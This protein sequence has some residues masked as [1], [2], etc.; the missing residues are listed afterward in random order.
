MVLFVAVIGLAGVLWGWSEARRSADDARVA[1]AEAREAAQNERW[2]RYRVNVMAA[3]GALRL[4]DTTAARHALDDAPVQHRDWVWS[5]LRAQ[6]DR[7]RAVLR[8]RGTDT[9]NAVFTPGGRRAL[10]VGEDGT[11]RVWDVTER[12]E[13]EPLPRGTKARCP[14]LSADGTVLAY[15]AADHTVHLCDPTT[16]HTRALLRGHEGDVHEISFGPD[17]TR[18]V[19]ASDDG[20]LR[21]WDAGSGGQLRTFRA[22]RDAAKPLLLSPNGRFVVTRGRATEPAAYLWDLDSDRP[23]VPLDGA[24]GGIHMIRFS[25]SGDRLVTVRRFPQTDIQLWDVGTGQR[26]AT[27]AGHK[28][29]VS[30]AT[31]SPDGRRLLTTSMDRTIRVWDVSPGAAARSSDAL[32]VLDGHS[33]WVYHA[34]FSPDGTRVLSSSHDRTLCYWDA[35]TGKPIAVL[36]GH[37]DPVIAAAFRTDGTLVSAS[38]DG[39]LRLWDVTGAES[40][41]AI[42]GHTNFVYNVA[43]FPDG[44]R[45]ASAAWDGTARVWNATTGREL[46]KLD[47]AGDQYVSAVAVH[48]GGQMVAT[49][50]RHEDAAQNSVRLWDVGAE[51]VLHTWKLPTNWQDGRLAFAPRGDLLAAGGVDGRVRL[52]DVGT[53]AEVG[54]LEG[55]SWP[56]RDVAFSPDGTLLAGAGDD[57]DGSVRI[58]D[59]RSRKQVRVL[60]GHKRGVYTVAW[61]RTGTMLASGSNDHTVR[62]WDTTTWAPFDPL[63]QGTNVYGVAFTADGKL[64]ACAC[65][66]NLIRMWDAQTRRELAKLSGHSDYV[67]H[68]AFSPD[69]TRMVSASG[70]RT[71]RVWDTLSNNERAGAT[72]DPANRP[73]PAKE[74]R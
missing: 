36:S 28:N 2:E 10:L 17:Q 13:Y 24:T 44:E 71:L 39:T 22:P 52:W 74:P 23:P 38:V 60:T 53:R 11:I 27:L 21:V 33:G 59:V 49:L 3:S 45:V 40:G 46:H 14:T 34:S 20:T 43:F 6:L 19:T 64:L 5:Q 66:D 68:L 69:G 56:I 32:L 61:N 50:S 16:G 31:F 51:R 41:Y 1:A 57:G 55:G 7:S 54:V 12:T 70:D 67:H 65:A 62:L 42:R 18:I 72:P 9:R 47:H 29:Q 15:A 8:G 58:W 25:P 63:F 73:C 26:L 35:R 30:H 4:H 37:T 48:P